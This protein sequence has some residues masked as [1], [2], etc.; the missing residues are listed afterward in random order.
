MRQDGAFQEGVELALD[1]LRQFGACCSLSPQASLHDVAIRTRPRARE[2]TIVPMK[3]TKNH[4]VAASVVCQ[5]RPCSNDVA[6]NSTNNQP[7]SL[8]C[9]SVASSTLPVWAHIQI[10]RSR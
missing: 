6:G 7:V 3:T 4:S 10:I 1:E 5:A 8:A 2:R 9:I